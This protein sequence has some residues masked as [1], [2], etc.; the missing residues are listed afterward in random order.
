MK[1]KKLLR[2]DSLFQS[3]DPFQKNQ[4]A[5]ELVRFRVLNQLLPV[6]YMISGLLFSLTLFLIPF[7]TLYAAYRLFGSD[8]ELMPILLSSSLFFCFYSLLFG[9]LLINS[10]IPFLKEWKEKLGFTE[11]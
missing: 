3:P 1:N 9:F 11:V 4:P 8:I 6:H 5:S 10:R 2:N 7:G